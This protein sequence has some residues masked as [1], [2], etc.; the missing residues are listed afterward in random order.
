LAAPRTQANQP[1]WKMMKFH[2]LAT[3]QHPKKKASAEGQWPFEFGGES[4]I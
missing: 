3:T 2:N 4:G 1:S